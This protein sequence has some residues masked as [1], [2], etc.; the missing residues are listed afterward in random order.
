VRRV[1]RSAPC[2]A[3][4]ISPARTLAITRSP[5]SLNKR[6][7]SFFRQRPEIAHL[8]SHGV[9]FA[10]H[11]EQREERRHERAHTRPAP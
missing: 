8:S 4:T 7:L 11:E 1:V 6:A 9:A 5:V 2:A 10:Q 3:A